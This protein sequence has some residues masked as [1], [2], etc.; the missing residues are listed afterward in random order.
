MQITRGRVWFILE[1]SAESEVHILHQTHSGSSPAADEPVALVGSGRCGSTL[2]QSILNTNPDFL[3]W[4]EHN[5]FLRD[6][7]A[8]YYR[9][10][11]ARFPAKSELSPET[12][13]GMLRDSRRWAAWD[14]LVNEAQFLDCFRS[15]IRAFF[16]DPTGRAIHWGFKEIRYALDT[17]C[18]AL[19]LMFDCFPR[20]RLI[21]LARE[22][23]STIFSIL[24]RWVFGGIPDGN[25]D[26]EQLDQRILELAN[27]WHAQYLKLHSLSDKYP[28]NCLLVRYE[29]LDSPQT[30]EELSGFFKTSAFDYKSRL[31]RVNDASNKTSPTAALIRQRIEALQPEI[32][33][34]TL[35][36]RT[37][38]GY[39]AQHAPRRA[40]PVLLGRKMTFPF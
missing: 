27:S 24:S 4:G 23:E 6:V 18:R 7:A 14:A 13:I 2:L 5:G 16:A 15:F 3:I 17:R 21:I 31:R 39:A 9:A 28:A 19:S 30:Y 35:Q 40:F 37:A 11:N 38:F 25:I 29:D 22:P 32:T 10:V 8:A 34:A 12:R 20:T 26:P 33:A 36:V 1:P